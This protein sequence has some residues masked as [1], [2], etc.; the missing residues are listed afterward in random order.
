M[1][2]F[3]LTKFKHTYLA[4]IRLRSIRQLFQGEAESLPFDLADLCDFP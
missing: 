1:I 2:L 4:R 3:E